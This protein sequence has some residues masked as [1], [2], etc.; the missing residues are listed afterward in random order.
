MCGR[1]SLLTNV[2]ALIERFEIEEVEVRPEP[3]YNVAPSQMVTTVVND[4]VRHLVSMR[5][6]LIPHWAKD[7]KI[8]NK[9]I[10]ARSE[11]LA[12]KPVFKP[13]LKKQRCLVLADG[14]Y[15]WQ[16]IGTTKKPM[17]IR[18][19]TREPF[20]L[21]GLYE[22]WK[23]PSEKII[24]S[25]TIITTEPNVLMKSIHNRMPVILKR[26][27]EDAWL[28]STNEDLTSLTKLLKKYPANKMEAYEVSTY[29]NSA[30]NTGAQCIR[31]ST[32]TTLDF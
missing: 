23:A 19:K 1:F 6:G 7:P 13:A 11:T 5:W 12:E 4:S 22:K 32:Q 31:P 25:C 26:N 20:A 14:F 16:K 8:G 10:N 2:K 21:A 28:D 24:Q 30:K 29:V 9:M 3:R 18:M 15:E 27:D 17:Y